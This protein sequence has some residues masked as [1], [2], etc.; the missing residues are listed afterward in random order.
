[1]AS[2]P[3]TNS[4]EH[5]SSFVDSFFRSFALANLL[6]K[7]GAYKVKG[8]SA[9]SVFQKLFTLVFSHKNLFQELHSTEKPEAAKDAFYRFI[10]SCHINWRRFTHLLAGKIINDRL[11]KLTSPDRVD[12]FIADDTIYER[13][14]SKKVELLSRVYDHCRRIYTRGFRLLTLGWSDGNTFIPV[15]SQLLAS[16][17]KKTRLQEAACVDKRTCGYQQRQRAQTKAPAVLLDMVQSALRAGICASYILFDSWFSTPATIIE[18]TKIQQTVGSTEKKLH[19]IAIVKKTSKVHYL[20]EGEKLSAPEIYAR[21]R[22][23][24]GSSRYLLSVEVKVCSSDGTEEISARLVYVRKR[25]KRKEYL[26]LLSTDMSLSEKEIIR[27]YGKRWQIEVFFKVCKSHLR[28]TKECQS[29]S[30]DAM[31][32]WNAIIFAR[33]MMLALGNRMQEDIRSVGELFFQNCEELSD[34]TLAKALQLLLDTF[35]EV[36]AEKYFLAEDE[37]ESLLVTFMNALPR[38]L[39]EKLPQCA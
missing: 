19:V 30:Y 26:V 4:F 2:L 3:R 6:K 17:E 25:G 7:V 38:E 34:I 14:R 39:K 35:L 27:I 28:L 20:Y 21:N 32:A 36:A 13:K 24:R 15:D 23:R 11:D 12:V 9:V 16:E 1:M 5:C 18:M 29:T 22:K 10:T 37:V 33:Y 31:T 8:I